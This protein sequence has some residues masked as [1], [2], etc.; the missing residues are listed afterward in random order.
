MS[1]RVHACRKNIYRL[2]TVG[3]A[4]PGLSSNVK[5]YLW[6]VIGAPTLSYGMESIHISNINMKH[7]KPSEGTNIKSVMGF[8]KRSHHSILLQA[9]NVQPINAVILSNAKSLFH[10]SFLENT[11][12]LHLQ[13]ILMA[14][15][16]IR[17]ETIKGTLIDNLVRNGIT[18]IDIAFSRPVRTTVEK[19]ED[20]TVDS[21]RYLICHENFIKPWSCEH[22][23]ASLL[24]KA[25]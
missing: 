25:F 1:N 19:N 9:L 18:P 3:M 14:K 11:P 2:T 16:I 10:R 7:L 17:N 12:L 5:S 22:I 13:S 8:S 4:Y 23:M 24:L 21:L 20:G 6:K 15:Y